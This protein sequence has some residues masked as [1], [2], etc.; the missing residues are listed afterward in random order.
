M[1]FEAC[2]GVG[3][4]HF[5]ANVHPVNFDRFAGYVEHIGDFFDGFA[6]FDQICHFNLSCGEVGVF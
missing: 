2:F 4:S 3:D 6:V 5:L 1:G